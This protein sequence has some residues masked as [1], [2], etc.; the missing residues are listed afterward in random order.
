[1]CMWWRKLL[2]HCERSWRDSNAPV[3]LVPCPAGDSAT[4]LVV[5]EGSISV[6]RRMGDV[7]SRFVRAVRD[8][9][10]PFEAPK[11]NSMFDGVKDAQR[12]LSAA[13]AV[14]A[15][16]PKCVAVIST[17]EW[18]QKHADARSA[19]CAILDRVSDDEASTSVARDFVAGLRGTNCAHELLDA[20]V[21]ARA[22][23]VDCFG[24]NTLSI[25]AARFAAR[26]LQQT[27]AWKANALASV[28]L[29]LAFDSDCDVS[30]QTTFNEYL[31]HH[32]QHCLL[33]E[34]LHAP[35]AH[36]VSECP[37]F[38]R[39]ISECSELLSGGELPH[40][41]MPSRPGLAGCFSVISGWLRCRSPAFAD[42]RGVEDAVAS[43]LSSESDGD[44]TWF[45]RNHYQYTA[46]GVFAGGASR[47]GISQSLRRAEWLTWTG[48]Q[49]KD[50]NMMRK[51]C[52]AF[53][54]A[55][56]PSSTGKYFLTVSK[57]FRKANCPTLALEFAMCAKRHIPRSSDL[58]S[59]THKLV[60]LLSLEASNFP[61]AYETAV[62]D[63]GG[64]D[65]PQLVRQLVAHLVDTRN[66]RCLY[67]LPLEASVDAW[68][69][70]IG[71]LKWKAD[72]CCVLESPLTPYN[73]L[74]SLFMRCG[75][76]T[77]ASQTLYEMA[78]KLQREASL[79]F[80]VPIVAENCPTIL[81]RMAKLL[82]SCLCTLQL[83][84]A[85]ASLLHRRDSAKLV[86]I[87]AGDLRN[88][89]ALVQAKYDLARLFASR[90]HVLGVDVFTA[91]PRDVAVMLADGDLLASA[92]TVARMY[93]EKVDAKPIF[94]KLAIKCSCSPS[95][96]QSWASLEKYLNYFQ[97]AVASPMVQRDAY[98]NVVIRTLLERRCPLPSWITK[99]FEDPSSARFSGTKNDVCAL[100]RMLIDSGST[101]N[102]RRACAIA[103][104]AVE[105]TAPR[106]SS[107]SAIRAPWIPQGLLDDVLQCAESEGGALKAA[108]EQLEEA[109]RVF[110][111]KVLSVAD[112]ATPSLIAHLDG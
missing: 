22:R 62:I 49:H 105:S 46:F 34:I 63:N 39:L 3:A 25:T 40:A 59:V 65:M 109:I 81:D 67:E 102:V 110:F 45:L 79:S 83:A 104:M 54:D 85:K 32:S 24:Y 50:E 16:L 18:A 51:A 66:F 41:P 42:I 35:Y 97:G 53:L 47:G 70:A 48:M 19:K 6:L 91:S 33:R 15:M 28:V 60:F 96:H 73:A 90:G 13:S 30:D 52:S 1:M 8:A 92:F 101:S 56:P 82:A 9:G 5:R 106:L 80:D 100:I 99:P 61:L 20:I 31:E 11:V 75:S 58:G 78:W 112:S 37:W 111:T 17:K 98:H 76:F 2:G 87:T 74:F 64:S 94:R 21:T 103:T 7:E 12:L 38:T 93:P 14:A 43:A 95:E 29:L 36:F 84:G 4:A 77:E 44:F 108:R 72:S 69:L 55:Q 86:R 10:T 89:L 88:E 57:I 26:T 23:D 68:N 27:S 107:R 71:E